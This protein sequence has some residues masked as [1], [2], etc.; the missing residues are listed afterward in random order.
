MPK[1]SDAVLWK[2]WLRPQ[3][4]P[5]HLTAEERR[6]LWKMVLDHALAQHDATKQ[7]TA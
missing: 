1:R 4:Q 5:E 3:F 7:K 6:R 2:L